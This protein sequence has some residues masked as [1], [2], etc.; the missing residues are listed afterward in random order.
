[1]AAEKKERRLG[2]GGPHRGE[3]SGLHG[4]FGPKGLGEIRKPFSFFKS[5]YKFQTSLN[6]NQI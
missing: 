6:S 1:M 5:V 2:W 3:K 4:K